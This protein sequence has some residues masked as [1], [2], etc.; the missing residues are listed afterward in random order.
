MWK[1][2]NPTFL[3][4]CVFPCKRAGIIRCMQPRYIIMVCSY[5]KFGIILTTGREKRSTQTQTCV[6]A[7]K[8]KKTRQLL[9]Q[10]LRNQKLSVKNTKSKS[11][12]NLI[13]LLVS[14]FSRSIS[15]N[16]P[17]FFPYICISTCYL[18]S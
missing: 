4:A 18:V 3:S 11:N 17:K 15:Q 12:R 13:F 14:Y 2:K 8:L 1:T 16:F 9:N 6:F 10:Q 5:N 7:P